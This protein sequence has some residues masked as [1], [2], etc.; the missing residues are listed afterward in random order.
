MAKGPSSSAVVRG[1]VIHDIKEVEGVRQQEEQEDKRDE[2][3]GD[4]VNGEVEEIRRD[5][6]HSPTR[7]RLD[8]SS[9]FIRRGGTL[10]LVHAG[11][12]H[13]L[14][15]GP[16][17]KLHSEE[18][19]VPPHAGRP[20]LLAVGCTSLHT[21]FGSEVHFS[22]HRKASPTRCR[23]NLSSHF[24]RKRGTVPLTQDGQSHSL[25]AGP[26][27]TLHSEERTFLLTHEGQS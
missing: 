6:Q 7:G 11:Q 19:D 16:T 18:R 4:E 9:H 5:A 15:A 8:L 27:F 26:P 1:L 13:S 23:L 22:S 17:P 21:S 14:S 2:E 3:M 20:V 25:S 12:S 10:T 24:I